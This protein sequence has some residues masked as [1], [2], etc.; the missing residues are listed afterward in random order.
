MY[1]CGTFTCVFV[2]ALEVFAITEFSE[3]FAIFPQMMR[4]PGIANVYSPALLGKFSTGSAQSVY[5]SPHREP[6]TRRGKQVI[7]VMLSRPTASLC[8]YYMIEDV[9]L[10]NRI[11]CQYFVAPKPRECIETGALREMAE[12]LPF[13]FVIALQNR[14]SRFLFVH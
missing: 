7:L 14:V 5:K 10:N 9:F 4:N 3:M 8:V 1:R 13:L 12:S 2:Y 11:D 6:P